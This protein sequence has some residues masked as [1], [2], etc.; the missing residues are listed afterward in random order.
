M[1]W[2]FLLQ[3][4]FIPDRNTH[5]AI[6]VPL[7]L[8]EQA[9]C[10]RWESLDSITPEVRAACAVMLEALPTSLTED[11][12]M[13]DDLQESGEDST[14][15][16]ATRCTALRYRIA[17]KMLMAACVGQPAATAETSAFARL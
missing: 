5:D 14:H 11:L 17:K 7:G 12:K 16:H 15:G 4:G 1:S 8:G 3:Y 10:V 6:T 9:V 13:L 2:Q